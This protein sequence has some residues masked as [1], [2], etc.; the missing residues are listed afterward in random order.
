M[1]E[2]DGA[3]IR[4]ALAWASRQG[5]ER[6][7]AQRL[8]AH[9]FQVD[10]AWLIGHDEQ[11]LAPAQRLKFISQVGA[12]LRDVPLAY[13]LGEQEFHGL[14]LQVSPA[15]LVPRADTE[16]LVDWALEILATLPRGATPSVIDLGTGSGAIA[17]AVKSG[18]PGAD[19]HMSDLSPQALDVAQANALRLGLKVG[20][21]LGSWWDAAPALAFDLVLSNPPYI[22]AG[23]PHLP[24]LHS[25]PAL[26]L[27]PGGDGLSALQTIVTGAAARMRPGAWLLLEHGYDQSGQVQ[28]MLSE[29][30]FESL[31]CR[32]DLGGQP[33]VTGGQRPMCDL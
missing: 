15:V 6:L 25:E 14:T 7:D 29:A 33:R 20:A 31:H 28:K 8:L 13:L 23:D 3:R 2:P 5:L 9:L 30:G 24:A 27:S 12:R 16:V 18:W 32:R 4:D 21:H 19:M 17:L 11:T 22:A 26:A 10:R 1:S